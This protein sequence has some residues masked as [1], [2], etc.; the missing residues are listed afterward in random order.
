MARQ[1]VAEVPE[2]R[3]GMQI[4]QVLTE[5]KGGMDWFCWAKKK[6]EERREG[7]EEEVREGRG[8]G[9]GWEEERKA[10]WEGSHSF[11]V[12]NLRSDP[13]SCL[14]IPFLMRN[15]KNPRALTQGVRNCCGPSRGCLPQAYHGPSQLDPM[16][17]LSRC[18]PTQSCLTVRPQ[19]L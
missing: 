11:F 13:R 2:K 18:M 16:H 7:K 10:Q 1:P 3:A 14:Q 8:E 15:R 6:T 4:T 17:L 5:L 19:G 9:G 12:L